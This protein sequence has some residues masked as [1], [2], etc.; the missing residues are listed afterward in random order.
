M[1]DWVEITDEVKKAKYGPPYWTLIRKPGTKLS[2]P[3]SVD[4]MAA[5]FL[6]GKSNGTGPIEVHDILI[7]EKIGSGQFSEVYKAL[8]LDSTS[9]ALKKIHSQEDFDK[10]EELLR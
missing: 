7:K 1:G 9:V 4:M 3:L 2:R 8:W 10:E 5:T 6:S